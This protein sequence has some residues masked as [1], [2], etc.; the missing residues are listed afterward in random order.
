[1]YVQLAC[2]SGWYICIRSGAVFVRAP[3]NL[4]DEAWSF[5]VKGT[6]HASP[7]RCTRG[8]ERGTRE[9]SFLDQLHDVTASE[10]PEIN[11]GTVAPPQRKT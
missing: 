5:L 4:R 10:I 6:V 11:L 3:G 9:T 8:C 2:A 1:M 7:E